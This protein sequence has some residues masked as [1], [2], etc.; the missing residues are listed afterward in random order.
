MQRVVLTRQ[1]LN[2]LNR[3]DR[4]FVMSLFHH[5]LDNEYLA[6]LGHTDIP[7]NA[8]REMQRKLIED[9]EDV[10]RVANTTGGIRT[11]VCNT[12][13]MWEKVRETE[14]LLTSGK[15]I[16][17]FDG[18][19]ESSYMVIGF[20]LL[21]VREDGK[22]DVYHMSTKTFYNK[23]HPT[24]AAVRNTAL[25]DAA[26]LLTVLLER[27]R[28]KVAN[29]WVTGVDWRYNTPYPNPE[30][31]HIEYNTDEAILRINIELGDDL[32]SALSACDPRSR[33]QSI[34][35]RLSSDPFWI[36]PATRGSCCN[37]SEKYGN[38][39]CPFKAFCDSQ[40]PANHVRF[41]LPY[42]DRE[43]CM[44]NGINTMDKLVELSYT[45]PTLENIDGDDGGVYSLSE[46]ALRT[47]RDW[48]ISHR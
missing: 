8:S 7:K 5:E 12:D 41:H 22:W 11:V 37:V 6:N 20:S 31:G 25:T 21:V 14:R 32:A 26:P 19:L 39:T 38:Y 3:C 47:M 17:I 23:A 35:S 40:L 16:A 4:A 15:P 9:S 2:E 33:I 48:E 34:M 36:P 28:D 30:T 10:R 24:D 1:L 13:D 18:A 29:V 46:I 42:H 45:Y 43:K 27:Y 44:K